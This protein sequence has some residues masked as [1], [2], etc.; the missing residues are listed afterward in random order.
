MRDNKHGFF[1][2]AGIVSGFVIALI[3]GVWMIS[4]AMTIYDKNYNVCI[5]SFDD[6]SRSWHDIAKFERTESGYKLVYLDPLAAE[7]D[8]GD[9]NSGFLSIYIHP[10]QADLG[11]YNE[12]SSSNLE[13]NCTNA[14]LNYVNAD[15]TEIDIA[16]STAFDIVARV[17]GDDDHCKRGSDWWDTDLNCTLTYSDGSET[18]AQPDAS[19]ATHNASTSTYL[20]MNFVWDGSG[21]GYTISKGA[22]SEIQEII[23]SAYY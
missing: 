22:T 9:G 19:F 16:H 7:A 10:H 13:T 20:Y 15:D 21:S 11:G 14:G 4:G 1:K 6:D 3:V 17:R 2:K 18:D 23:F 8:P 5:D 12:N